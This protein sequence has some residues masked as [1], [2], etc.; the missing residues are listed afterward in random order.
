VIIN[1]SF[2]LQ[3]DRRL[4]Q[5]QKPATNKIAMLPKVMS[6]LKKHDLQ[7]AFLEH[8]VLSV[9]TDWLAPMPD[10]SMPSL[11]IRDNILKL[12]WEV[13]KIQSVFFFFYRFV[14]DNEVTVID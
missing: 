2:V 1:G 3:E 6:Q 5:L 12:L 9:L 14:N 10:R 11:K 8:N 13:S 7:L 4:N